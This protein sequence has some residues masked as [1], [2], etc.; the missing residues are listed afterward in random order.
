MES[1]SHLLTLLE[2]VD[3]NRQERATK[4]NDSSSRGHL[5]VKLIMESRPSHHATAGVSGTTMTVMTSALTFVDLAGSE[6]SRQNDDEDKLRLKEGSNINKSLLALGTV[7]RLLAAGSLHHIPYRNSKLTRILQPALGGNGR[8][9]II[10]TVS[11]CH[12]Q[13]EYTRS[14][15]NFAQ[16]A[17]KVTTQPRVNQV[18]D[19]KAQIKSLQA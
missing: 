15:I 2:R 12:S 18:K 11:P 4:Q 10:C 9:A 1:A 17:K 13:L 7:I 14:T 16:H 3:R 6:R 5:I 19:T 8:T